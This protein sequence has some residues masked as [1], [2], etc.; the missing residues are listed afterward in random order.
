MLLAFISVRPQPT[1]PAIT[2]A[3]MHFQRLFI[4]VL[5][6]KGDVSTS[7]YIACVEGSRK[8]SVL[9]VPN[10]ARKKSRRRWNSCLLLYHYYAHQRLCKSPTACKRCVGRASLD[11]TSAKGRCLRTYRRSQM[12]SAVREGFMCQ[13][14]THQALNDHE[15]P[16]GPLAKQTLVRCRWTPLPIRCGVLG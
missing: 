3:Y 6:P 9:Q 2:I 7:R 13:R 16:F 15:Q 1:T 11:L 5:R 10:E 14:C 4:G 12:M 8:H